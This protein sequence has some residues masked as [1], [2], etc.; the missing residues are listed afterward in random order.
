M[1]TGIVEETGSLLSIERGAE[2][3]ILTIRANLVL[4]GTK[5]GD[6]I[7]VNGVCLTVTR[8]GQDRFSADVMAET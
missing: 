6:S 7:A 2:S 4:E 5:V 3:A 1:F 8:L